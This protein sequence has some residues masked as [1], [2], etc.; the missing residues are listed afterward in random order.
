MSWSTKVRRL[1][2]RR[3]DPGPITRAGVVSLWAPGAVSWE[4]HPPGSRRMTPACRTPVWQ[5]RNHPAT[6]RIERPSMSTA[7]MQYLARSMGPPQNGCPR[8]AD[9]S[10]PRNYGTSDRSAQSTA[11]RR[12]GDPAGTGRNPLAPRQRGARSWAGGPP[13]RGARRGPGEA[14]GGLQ[15]KTFLPCPSTRI[16]EA[17]SWG[18]AKD[19]TLRIPPDDALR[20]DVP[21]TV[22]FSTGRQIASLLSPYRRDRLHGAGRSGEGLIESSWVITNRPRRLRL[23]YR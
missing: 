6:A 9:T 3:S 11:P 15:A 20:C 7:S 17:G 19:D 2:I 1:P 23:A 14:G 21:S 8:F 4:T 16:V 10:C 13:G 22:G 18:V 5:A 12:H